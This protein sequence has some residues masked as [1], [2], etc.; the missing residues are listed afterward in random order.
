[1]FVCDICGLSKD[2]NEKLIRHKNTN[3]NCRKFTF[4]CNLCNVK[5]YLTNEELNRHLDKHRYKTFS[6]ACDKCKRTFKFERHVR[7]H[8]CKIKEK[9]KINCN[10]CDHQATTEANLQRHTISMHP[11]PDQI[12]R[13]ERKCLTSSKLIRSTN[14]RTSSDKL[15]LKIVRENNFPEITEALMSSICNYAKI[16]HRFEDDKLYYL[17][18]CHFPIGTGE[19]WV[20]AIVGTNGIFDYKLVNGPIDSNDMVK[21]IFSMKELPINSLL[22]MDNCSI[23][24]SGNVVEAFEKYTTKFSG[25]FIYLPPNLTMQLNPIEALFEQIRKELHSLMKTILTNINQKNKYVYT[26]M[27]LMSLL[28]HK[29]NVLQLMFTAY[30]SSRINLILLLNYDIIDEGLD[31]RRQLG[32]AVLNGPIKADQQLHHPS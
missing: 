26:N 7:L 21:I 27:M 28:E 3:P 15:K 30:T 25:K 9:I 12:A 17:D 1:M 29:R 2:K 6:F 20:C 11:N 10:L 5:P 23:H 13:R 19:I 14:T 8:W 32:I 16:I 18:E 4:K 31:E 22:I 24:L